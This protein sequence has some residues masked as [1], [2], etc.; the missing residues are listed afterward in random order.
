MVDPARFFSPLMETKMTNPTHTTD[1]SACETPSFWRS[2]T[3]IVFCIAVAVGGFFLL[4][5]HWVHAQGY[6]PY[7]LLLA[8]PLMHLFMHGGHGGHGHGQ[9]ANKPDKEKPDAS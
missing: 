3:G 1:H 7:L 5:E 2:R 8:C 4:K 9:V 6:L